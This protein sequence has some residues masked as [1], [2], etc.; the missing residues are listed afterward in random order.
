MNKRV[1]PNNRRPTVGRRMHFK[2]VQ[3]T[4]KLP[5]VPKTR[6]TIGEGEDARSYCNVPS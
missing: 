2:L 5:S 4:R 3:S 6:K 1:L